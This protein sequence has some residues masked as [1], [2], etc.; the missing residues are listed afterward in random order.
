MFWDEMG[1]I[2]VIKKMLENISHIN[3][4]LKRCI[5]KDGEHVQV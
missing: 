3:G 5:K 2:P 1:L 4:H